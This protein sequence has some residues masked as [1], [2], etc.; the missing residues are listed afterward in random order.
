[1]VFRILLPLLFVMCTACSE[2]NGICDIR[3]PGHTPSCDW[4]T[5]VERF[6]DKFPS[7]TDKNNDIICV[8]HGEWPEHS[9]PP[10]DVGI[11]PN[12]DIKQVYAYNCHRSL[13][14]NKL[15]CSTKVEVYHPSIK[16]RLEYV[17]NKLVC[18]CDNKDQCLKR[19]KKYVRNRTKRKEKK[20]KD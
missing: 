2:Q 7:Q 11:N 18:S 12:A 5:I 15:F 16:N 19:E 20:E 3:N 17:E 4:A 13:K 10:C 1:M 6:N 9:R 14:E 8:N